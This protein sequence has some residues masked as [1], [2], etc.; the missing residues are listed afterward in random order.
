MTTLDKKHMLEKIL[1]DNGLYR[2][3]GGGEEGLDS[4][5]REDFLEEVTAQV[6]PECLD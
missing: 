6:R 4:V 2:D 5:I 3:V 1:Q